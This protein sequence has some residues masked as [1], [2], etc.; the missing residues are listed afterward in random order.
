MSLDCEDRTTPGVSRR[1]RRVRASL[2]LVT[3]LVLILRALPV[4]ALADT[5]L[6]K[7]FVYLRDADPTIVQDIRYAGSHNFVGRPIEGY[8]AAECILSDR[9]ATALKTVQGMLA[10]KK[11]SLIVWDCYRPRRA[12]DDFLRW[13]RDPAHAEMK[14]EFY[15]RTDKQKLFALGYLATRSAHSRGSTVDLGIVPST[16]SLPPRNPPPA[17]KACTLPK[18]ERFED[19]TIDLGTGY[20]CLDVMGNTLNASVGEAA[21][22]NRQLLKSTMAKAGFR[23]YAR[24]WWHFELVNE[25][26]SQ[27]FDFEVSAARSSNERPAR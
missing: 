12:V 6:P 3:G 10:E 27:G 19:G 14:A 22:R 25:P 24:E 13:S 15:P 5:A 20:D 4:P 2:V 7:G 21:R 18:G 8:L 16:F 11:L 23:P 17:L 9:A 1:K 26:F